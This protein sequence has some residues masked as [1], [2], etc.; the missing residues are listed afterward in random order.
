MTIANRLFVLLPPVGLLG[1]G[2][3]T[4]KPLHPQRRA[5]DWI[6]LLNV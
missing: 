6:L 4:P 2:V 3:L 5:S 1:F